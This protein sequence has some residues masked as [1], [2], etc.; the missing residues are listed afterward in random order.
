LFLDFSSRL[1][2]SVD[3]RSRDLPQR[4]LPFDAELNPKPAFFAPRDGLASKGMSRQR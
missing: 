1:D 3:F 4:P 2:Y